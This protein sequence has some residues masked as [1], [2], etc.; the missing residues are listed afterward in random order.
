[1]KKSNP[2]SLLQALCLYRDQMAMLFTLCLVLLGLSLVTL[3]FV[4][5]PSPGYF[6]SVIN[7]VTLAVIMIPLGAALRYCRNVE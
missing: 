2:E 6:V 1:M 5:P 3:L 4:S 7:V